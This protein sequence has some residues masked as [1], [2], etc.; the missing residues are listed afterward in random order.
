MTAETA[1]GV[2]PTLSSEPATVTSSGAKGAGTST[3]IRTVNLPLNSLMRPS[4]RSRRMCDGEKTGSPNAR[5]SVAFTT[6]LVGMKNSE[7]GL[8]DCVW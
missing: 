4:V 1:T 5:P 7:R 3:G 6:T 2:V 8:L